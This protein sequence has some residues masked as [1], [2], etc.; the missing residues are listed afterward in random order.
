MVD[1]PAGDPVTPPAPSPDVTPPA[2]TPPPAPVANAT[3]PAEVEALRKSLEQ[4]Q[5]RTRQLENE[6]A[7]ADKAAEDA[8]A[9][10]LERQNEFKTLYETSEAKRKELEN[11]KE[12]K[13]KSDEVKTES[14]KVLADYSP[15]VR[16][17]A[18]T[19]GLSLTDTDA[20][21][22]EAFKA[23]LEEVK[24]MVGPA[25]VNP[26]N[27]NTPTPPGPTVTD[28]DGVIKTPL[29][30]DSDKLDSIFAS[31]PGIAGMMSPPP[32]Q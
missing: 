14:D 2:A 13:T 5:L 18:E 12:L 24:G 21:T 25:K 8:K 20:A 1:T 3:D 31:M 32:Q 16:K 26:N 27:P 10:E 15:E 4:Q 11:E 29:S 30:R 19:T 6:K 7:A 22:V 17:L 23:K 28:A 9:K